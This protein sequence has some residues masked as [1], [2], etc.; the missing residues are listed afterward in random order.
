M[1]N[2]T[3][4][5]FIMLRV[6][7]GNIEK[8]NKLDLTKTVSNIEKILDIKKDIESVKVTLDEALYQ[9]VSTFTEEERHLSNFTLKVK[10]NIF[11]GRP[12]NISPEYTHEIRSRILKKDLHLLLTWHQKIHEIEKLM[13]DTKKIFDTELVIANTNLASEMDNSE[14]KKGMAIANPSYLTT[15]NKN[16]KK[17]WHPHKQFARTSISYLN[18]IT[19]KT[20]PFSTFT[21]IG[22]TSFTPQENHIKEDK[23]YRYN[24]CSVTKALC[25]ELVFEMVKKAEFQPYFTYEKNTS[26]RFVTPTNIQYVVSDFS[27]ANGFAWRNDNLITKNL[28]EDQLLFLQNVEKSTYD[29][30]VASTPIPFSKLIDMQLIKPVLPF[31]RKTEQPL[32]V[33]GEFLKNK[34]TFKTRRIARIAKWIEDCILL[35]EGSDSRKRISYQKFIYLQTKRMFDM[36]SSSYSSKVL[37]NSLIYENARSERK[38][39]PLGKYVKQDLEYL[40]EHMRKYMFVTHVYE[41]LC[42]HFIQLF[43]RGGVCTDIKEFLYSFESRKDRVRLMKKALRK[44]KQLANALVQERIFAPISDSASPPNATIFYQI[45]AE[46]GYEDIINGNYK[47]V[48]NQ[49]SS[50]QGG[51]LLRFESMFSDEKGDLKKRMG[52]WIQSMYPNSEVVNLPVISE[53]NNL[54]SD[55]GITKRS[56]RIGGE[57][58]TTEEYDDYLLEDLILVHCDDNNTLTLMNKERK[59]IAPIYLGTVPQHMHYG[60]ISYILTISMPWINAFDI[61]GTSPFST[62]TAPPEKVEFHERLE[63]GRIV[64]KRAKWV[65]PRYLFPIKEQHE[66]SYAY[67][68]RIKEFQKEYNLPEEGFLANDQAKFSIDTKKRKPLYF[69]FNNYHSIEAA[70]QT[71]LEGQ[72]LAISFTEALPNKAT[73]W[74]KDDEGQFYTT[75]YMSL[76]KWSRDNINIRSEENEELGIL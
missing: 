9:L 55:R 76:L 72:V 57:T 14:W 49:G 63:S 25:S 17:L 73:H 7:G 36:V 50:G 48:L 41:L 40:A 67:F 38:H 46:N 26:I 24:F 70:V 35:M 66:N 75:E 3:V 19:A 27:I 62:K 53:F 6:A 12:L 23:N 54:Q 8:L 74:L 69:N 43:G 45:A 2:E 58:S 34:Q 64:L 4:A 60:I 18:R 71:L 47:L 21:K 15:F 42:D 29:E 61:N 30:I 10:R 13:I 39:P 20:S 32:F 33:L 31:S 11:N 1:T 52:D 51:L 5:P 28:N 59:P 37:N 16:K 22:M 68:L 44:D 65:I 56:L